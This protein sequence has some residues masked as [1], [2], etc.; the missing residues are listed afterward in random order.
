MKNLSWFNKFIFLLNMVLTLVTF[1]GYVLPFLAPKL[2]PL[3]SVLTLFLPTLLIFNCLFVFYWAIQLKRQILLSGILLLIGM[4]FISKFYKFGRESVPIDV[5]DFTI[6]SYNV[7]YFNLYDW[8]DDDVEKNIQDFFVQKKPDILCI[9]EFYTKN[10]LDFSDYPYQYIF[11][12][13]EGKG[14]KSKRMAQTI[15][16]KFPIINKG[17]IDFENSSNVAIYADILIG[18]DT[19]RVYNIHLQSISISRD[20]HEEVDQSKSEIIFYRISK[21]FKMQQL[22]A[23]LIKEHK[24]Q[25]AFPI[26]ICGDMNNSAFSYVYR[27][28]RGSL[29]DCFEEKGS[30]LGSTYPYKYYPARIDYIF[31]DKRLKIKSFKNFTG[32]VNSDHLPI[33]SRLSFDTDLN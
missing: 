31:A 1:V 14:N 2:F 24:K 23:E 15:F 25:C 26:I 16:S 17:D 11:H 13:D 22:Q 28:I 9:Q 27:S 21:A 19:V 10:R 33:M 3:L 29:L 12:I 18:K 8:I 7:R 5:S 20:I 32:F 4:P 30:G 6:M